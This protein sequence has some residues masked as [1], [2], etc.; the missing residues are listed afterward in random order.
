VVTR[1]VAHFHPHRG[2]GAEPFSKSRQ[3]STAAAQLNAFWGPP[4]FFCFFVA[5]K[6]GL[7]FFLFFFP[8]G[9]TPR[10]FSIVLGIRA[11]PEGLPEDLSKKLSQEASLSGHLHHRSGL[12]NRP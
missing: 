8:G 6:K 12:L 7:F 4:L 1:N 9:G 11:H 2:A 5:K 10:G 3:R